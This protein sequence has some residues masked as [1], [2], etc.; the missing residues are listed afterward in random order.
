MSLTIVFSLLVC[1]TLLFNCSGNSPEREVN[2]DSSL[3]NQTETTDTLVT[4]INDLLQRFY[5]S[6]Q[7]Y[8]ANPFDFYALKKKTMHMHTGHAP[9]FKEEFL[10]KALD[11]TYRFYCY[12][13]VE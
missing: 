3:R 12:W 13:A 11:S 7:T 6:L 1:C 4:E 8:F 5:D 9:D 2:T 10:Q